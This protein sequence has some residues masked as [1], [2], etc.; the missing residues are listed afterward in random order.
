MKKHK[1]QLKQQLKHFFA[2]IKKINWKFSAA[3]KDNKLLAFSDF[4]RIHWIFE[5]FWIFQFFFSLN[6]AKFLIKLQRVFPKLPINYSNQGPNLHFMI[7]HAKTESHW[8][9]CNLFKVFIVL[10]IGIVVTKIWNVN[11]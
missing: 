9:F 2:T 6:F 3:A 5:I 8:N 10:V 4:F 1:K 7:S 11:V